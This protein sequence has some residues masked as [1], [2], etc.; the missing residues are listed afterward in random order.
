M[1]LL[2]CHF[3]SVKLQ[4]FGEKILIGDFFKI[5]GTQEKNSQGPRTNFTLSS[6]SSY[7]LLAIL[8]NISE[9]EEWKNSNQEFSK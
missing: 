4:N 1:S 2:Y 8:K 5:T 9:I 7:G 6:Q 3:H